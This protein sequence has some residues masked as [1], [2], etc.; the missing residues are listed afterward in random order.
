M[1]EHFL[2]VILGLYGL[3]GLIWVV[4]VIVGPSAGALAG[5]VGGP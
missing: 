1:S 4:D 2:K 3:Y 5:K